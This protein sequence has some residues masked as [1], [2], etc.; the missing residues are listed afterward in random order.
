MPTEPSLVPPEEPRHAECSGCGDD[1][2]DADRAVVFRGL[3]YCPQCSALEAVH[4][5]ESYTARGP[6]LLAAAEV[7]ASYAEVVR[8]RALKRSA[9]DAAQANLRDA[10]ERLSRAFG[11]QP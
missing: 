8:E 6:D 9:H 2:I 4:A 1:E 7:I 10:R 11:G 5:A 3:T